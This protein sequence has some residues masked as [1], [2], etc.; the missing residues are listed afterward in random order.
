MF[1]VDTYAQV[2][3]AVL[4]E[5]R[6]RRSVAQELGLS[7]NTV[8]KMVKHHLPPG[9]RRKAAPVSPKLDAFT[10]IIDQILEDDKL[11]IKKQRHTAKRILERLRD[12]HGFTGGYTIVRSY[13]MKQKI[14]P[15][16]SILKHRVPRLLLICY[17][18]SPFIMC[19]HTDYLYISFIINFFMRVWFFYNLK[20]NPMLNIN[21]SGTV[22]L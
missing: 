17:Q 10:G 15:E 20:C 1:T 2:R 7:R 12:E 21:S 16:T 11:V 3:R 14:S 5:G 4:I 22:S 19:P 18:A 13:V 8:A 6:S 9:Y